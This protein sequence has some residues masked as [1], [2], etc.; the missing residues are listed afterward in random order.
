MAPGKAIDGDPSTMWNAGSRGTA[1]HPHFLIVKLRKPLR[2]DA[3]SL[4]DI[5][6]KPG[7][8]FLGFDNIYN[9]YIGSDGFSYT[10][11]AS[12]TLTESRDP[13][14]NSALVSVP[15]RLSTLRYVKYEVVGGSHWA[16][17]M[18]MEILVSQDLRPRR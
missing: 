12:G 9:L 10:K 1:T 16:H 5:V 13:K 11:I 4:K 17:L 3:V 6:W 7:G 2:V 18:E 15:K 8:T 14:W